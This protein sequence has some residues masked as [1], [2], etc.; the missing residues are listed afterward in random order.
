MTATVTLAHSGARFVVQGRQTILQAALAAG[1]DLDY[2]CMQGACGTCKA[3]I[4]AGD[5]E[6]EVDPDNKPAIGPKAI[7]RGYRL[8]CISIPRSPFVEVDL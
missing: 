8:L 6:M 4:L 2:S 3:L 1:L 7:E 5:V